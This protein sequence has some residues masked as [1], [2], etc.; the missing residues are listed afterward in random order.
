MISNVKYPDF[1]GSKYFP[2]KGD[3]CLNKWWYQGSDIKMSNKADIDLIDKFQMFPCPEWINYAKPLKEETVTAIFDDANHFSLTDEF[4]AKSVT[5]KISEGDKGEISRINQLYYTEDFTV[6]FAG[7][8]TMVQNYILQSHTK[9]IKNSELLYGYWDDRIGYLY[10]D[11]DLWSGK[12]FHLKPF[13]ANILA[14][15]SQQAIP[16][17]P[18]LLVFYMQK[19]GIYTGSLDT[20]NVAKI[21]YINDKSFINQ[22]TPIFDGLQVQNITISPGSDL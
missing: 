8:R 11:T 1:A 13:V 12:E 9:T 20:N 21:R 18:N 7:L 14:E 16:E 15:P 3:N 2:D 17:D 5:T 22:I 6:V 4:R 10:N 19:F